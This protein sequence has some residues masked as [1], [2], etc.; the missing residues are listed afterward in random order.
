MS[1][2]GIKQARPPSTE[3]KHWLLPLI[4]SSAF[5]MV[6][7]VSYLGIQCM[8]TTNMCLKRYMSLRASW[9][10]YRRG[11]KGAKLDTSSM[12]SLAWF[13]CLKQLSQQVNMD[14][15]GTSLAGLRMRIWHFWIL[16][17][18]FRSLSCQLSRDVPMSI[19]ILLTLDVCMA[20]AVK[21]CPSRAPKHQPL[22]ISTRLLLPQIWLTYTTA[23]N[24]NSKLN[25]SGYL[26][27]TCLQT[28]SSPV[29]VIL[30]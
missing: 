12:G 19:S 5:Q 25:V 28:S 26:L 29:E 7:I 30:G 2:S 20:A 4:T 18:N 10:S 15:N 16:P 3:R 8:T 6:S 11:R 27:S 24:C 13:F 9:L 17:S 21:W 1:Q 22:T 14:Y 23:T